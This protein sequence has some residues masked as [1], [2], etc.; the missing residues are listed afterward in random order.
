MKEIMK[1]GIILLVLCL[2]ATLALAVTNELTK[3][4]IAAQRA[5]KT[6]AARQEV[7]PLADPEGFVQ[8]EE[9][10]LNEVIAADSSV[11]DVYI[12]KSVDGEVI[13][14]VITTNPKGFG[15]IVETFV[16]IDTK[17]V[18]TGVRIGTHA[19]TP[20]LGDVATQ[21]EFYEQYN[22]MSV[23]HVIGVSK[24]SGSETEIQAI[25]G[26]TI[27]SKAV[28]DGVNSA[29]NAYNAFAN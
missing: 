19:E 14:Y 24:V 11:V 15:G 21:P 12:G 13:G 2:V 29:A 10:K 18:I 25:S 16:G 17:G 3:A 9:A 28:T 20:G 1:T 6:A 4:P 8:L 7:L 23:E 5:T 27:T 22:D 26:A